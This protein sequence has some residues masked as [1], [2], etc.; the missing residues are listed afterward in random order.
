MLSLLPPMQKWGRWKHLSDIAVVESRWMQSSYHSVGH[1]NP[2]V[3][4]CVGILGG[5]PVLSLL[6][7]SLISW[8]ILRTFDMLV[9]LLVSGNSRAL[10]THHQGHCLKSLWKPYSPPHKRLSLLLSV[11]PQRTETWTPLVAA[12]VN[13]SQITRRKPSPTWCHTFMEGLRDKEDRATGWR[14]WE[15]PNKGKGRLRLEL[16]EHPR[17]RTNSLLGLP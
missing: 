7:P 11:P 13:C 2:V 3:R 12:Y 16:V 9:L 14:R 6:T 15:R 1:G 8:G 4:P 10:Y 17:G 5:S